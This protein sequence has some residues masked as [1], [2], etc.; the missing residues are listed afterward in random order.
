MGQGDK[1]KGLLKNLENSIKNLPRDALNLWKKFNEDI[2]KGILLDNI[3][4]QKL[5]YAMRRIPDR[6]MKDA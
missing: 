4:A 2:K 5:K 6:T 3:R 1:V